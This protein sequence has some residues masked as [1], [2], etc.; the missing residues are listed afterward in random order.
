MGPGT[1]VTER[2]DCVLVSVTIVDWLGN[3]TLVGGFIPQF[4]TVTLDTELGARP[5]VDCF[6]N[7]ARPHWRT[8]AK[9]PLPRSQDL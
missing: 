4:A 5:V 6:D 2:E 1:L 8:A 3:K 9:I 7:R